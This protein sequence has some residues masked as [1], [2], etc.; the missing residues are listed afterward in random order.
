MLFDSG[1]I[2]LVGGAD[3][4]V[5]ALQNTGPGASPVTL[6]LVDAFGDNSQLFDVAAPASV[7]VVHDSPDAPP[8]AIIATINNVASTLVPSL[9]YEAFTPYE[10]LTPGAY[11]FGITPAS[12]TSQVLATQTL[13]LRAGSEQAIYAF[14]KLA[15]LVTQVTWDDRRRLATEAKLRIIQGSPSAGNADVYLTAPGAGIAS[16]TPTYS[17]VPFMGDTGFQGFAAGSYDLTVTVAGSKSAVIGPVTV[18]II[19]TG[20]YT[21]V[22]REAPGGGAPYGLILLDDFAP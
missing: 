14:G 9:T 4:V 20:V 12:N 8:V 2:S 16:L 22:A 15:N 6:S 13:T 18:S 17:G 11:T 10:S 7:R 3:L 5:T 19:N 21:V 1:T